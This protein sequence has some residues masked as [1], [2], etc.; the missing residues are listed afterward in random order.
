MI[1]EKFLLNKWV[2]T[3]IISLCS[4]LMASGGLSIM[5]NQI[6]IYGFDVASI[7][8]CYSIITAA[9]LISFSGPV[10]HHLLT[11]TKNL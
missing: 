4:M 5:R 7:L 8:V 9:I 3:T 11:K 10:L 2:F 6:L 1:I